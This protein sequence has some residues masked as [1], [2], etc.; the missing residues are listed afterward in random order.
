MLT[1]EIRKSLLNEAHN[2]IA[3]LAAKRGIETRRVFNSARDKME[4]HVPQ[5]VEKLM[6]K[7]EPTDSRKLRGS[8]LRLFELPEDAREAA[9]TVGSTIAAQAYE[10]FLLKKLSG[11]PEF[12]GTMGA[13]AKQRVMSE[14]RE[15]LEIA[16][17]NAELAVGSFAHTLKTADNKKEFN[18][19][20][21]VLSDLRE[22]TSKYAT[23]LTKFHK[24]FDAD[25]R[26]RFE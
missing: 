19:Q 8:L 10:A 3:N 17:R 12:F 25:F 15:R 20:M 2:H 1:P 18:A 26:R 7:S 23:L 13:E 6:R 4:R 14:C 16:N 22:S 9:R 24:E 11:E 21:S 5:F